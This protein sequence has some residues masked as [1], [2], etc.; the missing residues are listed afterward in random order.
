M[1]KQVGPA[2]SKPENFKGLRGRLVDQEGER[3]F[4]QGQGIR[5]HKQAGYMNAS[6][7][8]F[9]QTVDFILASKGGSI[10]E[11]AT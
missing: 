6:L 4:H 10:H 11:I 3:T 5:L 2:F 1:A 9:R 8:I 7:T